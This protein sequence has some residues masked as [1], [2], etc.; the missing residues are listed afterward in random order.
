MPN[1]ASAAPGADQASGFDPVRS[2]VV[3][4]SEQ[5]TDYRNPDGTYTSKMSTT[6]VNFQAPDGSWQPIDNRLRAEVGGG[7]T[8]SAN[9]WKVHF[10]QSEVEVNTPAGSVG[11]R[12]AGGLAVV[13]VTLAD[14]NGVRYQDVWRGADLKYIVEGGRV[15]ESVLIKDRSAGSSFAFEVRSGDSALA[16]DVDGSV[17]LAGELGARVRL[18]APTVLRADGAPVEA[19]RARLHAAGA[20]RVVLS[21]DPAWLAAQPDTAFPIDLDPTLKVAPNTTKSFKNDGFSCSSCAIRIGNARDGGDTYWRTVAH[22]PYESLFGD[23]VLSAAIGLGLAAGTANGYVTRVYWASA[24]SYAGAA[25][26]PTLLASAAIETGGSLTGSGLT[27]QIESWVS[28]RV[29]G[30][31]FGFL[32]AETGGLYTYKEFAAELAVNYDRPPAAP[33]GLAF[34]TPSRSCVTGSSRPQ[35]DGTY[36]FV[37]KATLSDPDGTNVK[38]TFELWNLSHT[39][40]LKAVTSAVVT[41]GHAVTVSF[42]AK[43]LTNGTSFAWRAQATDGTITGPYSGWCEATIFYP[44]PNV[45]TNVRFSTPQ[46]PCTTAAPSPAMRGDQTISLSA[47]LVDPDRRPLYATFQVVKTGDAATVYWSGK[48]ATV[49]SGSTVTVAVPAGRIPNNTEFSWHVNAWNGYLLSAWSGWCHGLTDNTAPSAPQ[50][51]SADFG[52]AGET[53]AGMVGVPG[54]VTV[55]GSTD[56]IK[57]VW[58]L[59]GALPATPPACGQT[60]NGVSTICVTAGQPASFSFEPVEAEPTVLVRDYDAAGNHGDGS[61]TFFV[62]EVTASHGWIT[63]NAE[64]TETTVADLPTVTN[65][66]DLNQGVASWAGDGLYGGALHMDGTS[67]TMARTASGALD[68]TQSFSVFA[69]VRQTGFESNIWQNIMVQEAGT[70]ESFGLSTDPNNHLLFCLQSSQPADGTF[71]GDCA[72][73]GVAPTLDGWDAVIA[74]WDAAAHELRLYLNGTLIASRAHDSTPATTGTFDVGCG[75][76]YGFHA[77]CWQGDVADPIVYQGVLDLDQIDYL[78][79][80]GY[81]G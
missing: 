42:P 66:L 4:R 49:A 55:T 29:S 53:P 54:T 9:S 65:P 12:P 60:M 59:T 27:N 73:S 72:W 57:Y 46:A 22:F 32:G 18:E 47:T 13:P 79:R 44:K 3:G 45:P 61:M 77:N 71:A 75:E 25:G 1:A 43:T 67:A 6:V 68:P 31:A 40:K 16:D 37:L 24:Y 11:I 23:K 64:G 36:P 56:T 26:H 20:G 21:V 15:K 8:N 78:S 2:V 69:L 10:R 38:A 70:T 5:Q 7:F 76:G 14:N 58:T 81:G 17:A 35:I 50:I 62:N 39:S 52:T 34:S 80:Y 41:S 19:A 74:V 28:G 51:S 63:D 33:T 48:S 30:G